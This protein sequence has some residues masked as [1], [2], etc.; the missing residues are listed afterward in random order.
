MVEKL[1]IPKEKERPPGC[2]PTVSSD[3]FIGCVKMK[4]RPGDLC[5]CLYQAFYVHFLN[6]SGLKIK[7]HRKMLRS[8]EILRLVVLYPTVSLPAKL[9][10]VQK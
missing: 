1:E 7:D 9:K 4:N 8:S 3:V 2:I 10:L 6:H 5:L